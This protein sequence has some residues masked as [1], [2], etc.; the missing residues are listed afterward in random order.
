MDQY[1]IYNFVLELF[2]N[3]RSEEEVAT[4]IHNNISLH[5]KVFILNVALI[6]FEKKQWTEAESQL[7]FGKQLRKHFNQ[8]TWVDEHN[9]FEHVILF[10]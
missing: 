10:K 8:E 1:E 6:R 3:L 9:C 5:N 4:L 2:L 7:H